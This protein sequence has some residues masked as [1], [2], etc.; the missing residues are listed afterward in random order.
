MSKRFCLALDLKSDFALI[1]AYKRCHIAFCGW[2]CGLRML[3]KAALNATLHGKSSVGDQLRRP[4][5]SR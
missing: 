1:V 3:G 4:E 5:P 2:G